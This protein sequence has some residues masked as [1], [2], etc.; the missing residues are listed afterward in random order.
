MLNIDEIQPHWIAGF[1]TLFELC[2]ISPDE[3]VIILSE[4]ASSPLHVHLAKLGLGQIGRHY[5]HLEL[6]LYLTRQALLCARQVPPRYWAHSRL[7]S[8]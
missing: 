4:T 3:Q 5:T 2:K 6:P 1:A 7:L 8:G